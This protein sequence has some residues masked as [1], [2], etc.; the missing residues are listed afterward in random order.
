M[1][2]DKTIGEQQEGRRP[3]RRPQTAQRPRPQVKREG[4]STDRAL[5]A[6]SKGRSTP[7]RRRED[8]VEEKPQQSGSLVT[9]T[10]QGLSEYFQ[11]VRSE[12]Q[13][14]TWPTRDDIRR[15]TIIVIVALI[16][17]AIALG[18]ISAAFTEMFRVGFETPVILL[19]F[20]LIVGVI[21]V[22]YYWMQNRRSST[23]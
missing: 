20:M 23:Y 12:L 22:V 10:T 8:E 13:K 6:A 4:A 15:L 16:L 3:R 19:G 2:A 18:L 7:A 1:P 9:R 21:G 5:A 11:G 17:S 14:V